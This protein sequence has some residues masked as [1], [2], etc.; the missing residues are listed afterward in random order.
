MADFV[1]Y[2]VGTGELAGQIA[3]ATGVR[4]PPGGV[5]AVTNRFDRP[6]ADKRSGNR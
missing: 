3:R 4:C 6:D 5:G 2:P 1:A